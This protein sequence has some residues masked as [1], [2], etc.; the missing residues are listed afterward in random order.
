MVC[1]LLCESGGF[2]GAQFRILLF[3]FID[4]TS[5][6]DQLLF[7]GEEGVA[8]GANFDADVAF[9]G[10]TGLERVLA[11]ADYVD[12]VIGRVYSS[13]HSVPFGEFPS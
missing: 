12:L 3:E 5:R 1:G 4:A 8:V 9:M 11:R 13:F 2:F 10:G 6:I 7:A